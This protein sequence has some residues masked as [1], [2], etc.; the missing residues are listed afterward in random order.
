MTSTQNVGR[1][2]IGDAFAGHQTR[3]RTPATAGN[4]SEG[5][6]SPAISIHRMAGGHYPALSEL[7]ATKPLVEKAVMHGTYG[8]A[9]LN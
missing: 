4:G 2:A 7:P 1:L 5:V 9:P 8:K 3:S 6:S